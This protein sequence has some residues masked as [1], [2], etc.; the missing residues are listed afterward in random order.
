LGKS[1]KNHI[2][3]QNNCHFLEAFEKIIHVAKHRR[4][5]LCERLASIAIGIL[6][7]GKLEKTC[8]NRLFGQ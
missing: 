1:E 5:P 4:R 6:R 2:F 3:C 8:T 7:I